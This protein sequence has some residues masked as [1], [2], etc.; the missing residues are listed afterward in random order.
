MRSRF[1]GSALRSLKKRWGRFAALAVACAALL[2]LVISLACSDGAPSGPGVRVL[3]EA[4]LTDIGSDA[5]AGDVMRAIEE[6]VK[7]RAAAFGVDGASVERPEPNR[8]L[9]TLPGVDQERARVLFL[10]TNTLEFR[11]PKTDQ[12][13]RIFCHSEDGQEFTVIPQQVT[14]NIVNG[15]SVTRC[16]GDDIEGAI[17]WEPATAAGDDGDVPLTGEFVLSEGITV[18]STPTPS[19]T[20]EFSEEGKAILAEITAAIVGKPLGIFVD[21]EQIATPLVLEPL[22]KGKLIITGYTLEDSRV[23]AALF[24]GGTLPAPIKVVSIEEVP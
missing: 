13:G 14:A 8:L 15:R 16:L 3:I 12:R 17:D 2:L 7:R 6:N 19:V 23:L 22:S 4:D 10:E 24:S 11:R 21:G 18:Q 5:D 1:S 20:L 9:V